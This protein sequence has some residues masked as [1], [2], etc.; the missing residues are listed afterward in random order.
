[1]YIFQFPCLALYSTYSEFLKYA[2][3]RCSAIWEEFVERTGKIEERLHNKADRKQ[4]FGDRMERQDVPS[5]QYTTSQRPPS[6]P[7]CS[8]RLLSQF[9]RHVFC[10][11]RIAGGCTFFRNGI[12]TTAKC[13]VGIHGEQISA[14]TPCR[15]LWFLEGSFCPISPSRS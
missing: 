1:M 13:E 11:F 5:T 8:S 14:Y 12:S 3:K 4:H 2:V 10:L 7:S 9:S 15:S 6:F